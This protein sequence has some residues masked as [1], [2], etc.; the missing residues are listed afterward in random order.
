MPTVSHDEAKNAAKDAFVQVISD[1]SDAS[2][3]LTKAEV[4]AV[5]KQAFKEM[6]DERAMQFGYFSAKWIAAAVGGAV[7]VFVLS[8]YGL[9]H[10]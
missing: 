1:H 6:L 9:P 5:M 8:R 3:S 4:K 7:L 2:L 10:L